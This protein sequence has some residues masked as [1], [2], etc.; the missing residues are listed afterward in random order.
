[1]VVLQHFSLL[2]NPWQPNRGERCFYLREK[3]GT[4]GERMGTFQL[5]VFV[6]AARGSVADFV[7][8][9]LL[10]PGHTGV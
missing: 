3:V 1:M 9:I 8:V 2:W 4:S 10:F 7:S 6:P 5:V